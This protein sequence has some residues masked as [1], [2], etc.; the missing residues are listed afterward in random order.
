[1]L[2]WVEKQVLACRPLAMRYFKQAKLKVR[3]KADDS[4]VTDADK[5]IEEKLR[6]AFAKS[7]PGER[8]VGEEFGA[9]G[10]EGNSYWTIDPIDGT[11]GFSRGLPSWGI[12]VSRVERGIP[13]LAVVDYPAVNVTLA[14]APGVPAYE[15][16]GTRI[17]RFRRAPK[18]PKL[19]DTVIFHGGARWW[20]GTH[21]E[22][23]FNELIRTC[24]LERAY[25]DCYGYLWL[26]RGN[27]DAVI[28]YGVKPWD[29]LPFAALAAATGRV[30]ADFSGKPHSLG[31][32]TVTAHPGLALHIG[33]ILR[34]VEGTIVV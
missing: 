10:P 3:R 14:T 34:G 28:E 6:K 19:N 5:V 32:Q 22:K 2:A 33:H 16:T 30:Q 26:F 23:G 13:N 20:Q 29:V 17:Q 1:M 27:A 11:R 8:I 4:P 12:L 21:F 25:G 18:P 15:R 24:L 9:S 7:F 31:P